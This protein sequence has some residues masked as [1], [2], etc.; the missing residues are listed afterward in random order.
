VPIIVTWL[1]ATAAFFRRARAGTAAGALTLAL[2]L[3]VVTVGS[4]LIIVALVARGR[5]GSARA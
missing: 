2:A 3:A 4:A 5:H 1:R